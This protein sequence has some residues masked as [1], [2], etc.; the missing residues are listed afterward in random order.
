MSTWRNSNQKP[1]WSININ[2]C[3][4]V[5]SYLLPVLAASIVLNVPK[6]LNILE[7]FSLVPPQYE[8]YVIKV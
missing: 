6:I 3:S 5:V 8:I 2:H 1:T 7:V 4:M